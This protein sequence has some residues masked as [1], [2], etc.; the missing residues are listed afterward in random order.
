MVL[1]YK[2]RAGG[3]FGWFQCDDEDFRQF[4]R[5]RRGTDLVWVVVQRA[6]VIWVW[7]YVAGCWYKKASLPW[8]CPAA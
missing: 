3:V 6:G 7:S 4:F 1:K 5:S 2:Y 8:W